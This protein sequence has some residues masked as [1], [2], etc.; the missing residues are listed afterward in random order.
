MSWDILSL[1][2]TE[3][4]QASMCLWMGRAA[5]LWFFLEERPQN[6]WGLCGKTSKLVCIGT[7]FVAWVKNKE[8]SWKKKNIK[9]R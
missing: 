8:L 1:G 9:N 6:M 3:Y 5:Q 2:G 4:A 7:P